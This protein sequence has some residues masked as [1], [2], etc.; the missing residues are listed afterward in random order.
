MNFKEFYKFSW[1]KLIL[2]VLITG[3]PLFLIVFQMGIVDGPPVSPLWKYL[4]MP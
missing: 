4:N 1:T 2:F 3:V